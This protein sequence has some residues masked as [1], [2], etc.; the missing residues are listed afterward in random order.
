M[1][2]ERFF[3]VLKID[4]ICGA[5]FFAGTAFAFLEIDASLLV[6]DIF[7]G[8]RLLVWHIDG[9]S[10]HEVFIVFIIHL[11]GAFFET[12][13]AGNAFLNIHISWM[14]QDFHV[15]IALF[16]IDPYDFGEGHQLN[17]EMP[18]DLDQFGRENSHGAVIG[19]ECLVQL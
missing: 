5:E 15:K 3:L 16:A 13:A 18:A 17:V 9:L 19:G 6:Y 1:Q 10:F 14:P 8:N 4:C 7:Q 11:F 2:C 12:C